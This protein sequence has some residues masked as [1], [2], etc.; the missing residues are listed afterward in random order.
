MTIEECRILLGSDAVGKSDA[1]IEAIRDEL[2]Q[3]AS[4]L[5]SK[6]NG[7]APLLFGK[8]GPQKPVDCASFQKASRSSSS[9]NHP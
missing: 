6:V 9:Q 5:Y 1:Q 4:T 2:A 7:T 3:I 8:L